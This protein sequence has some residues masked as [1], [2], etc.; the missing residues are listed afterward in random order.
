MKIWK[1]FKSLLAKN[2]K[3]LL[4]GTILI[5]ALSVWAMHE[6]YDMDVSIGSEK[7]YFCLSLVSNK[8]DKQEIPLSAN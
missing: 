4:I 7:G 8:K 6:N 1:C 5:F 3:M 2:L